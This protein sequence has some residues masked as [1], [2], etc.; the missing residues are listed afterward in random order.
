[1]D[2]IGHV[3]AAP[4][5]QAPVLCVLA[6]VLGFLAAVLGPES[7]L[8][9]PNPKYIL[10]LLKIVEIKVMYKIDSRGSKNRILGRTLSMRLPNNEG[11]KY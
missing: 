10:I 9:K 2:V 6:A 5:P 1:M 4:G 8:N 3:A 11:L 7:V